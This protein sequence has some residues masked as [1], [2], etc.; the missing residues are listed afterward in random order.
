MT[1]MDGKGKTMADAC[2]WETVAM[3]LVVWIVIAITGRRRHG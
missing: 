2:G 1:A 3:A